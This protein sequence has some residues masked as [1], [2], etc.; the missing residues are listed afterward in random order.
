MP[1]CLVDSTAACVALHQSDHSR[2]YKLLREGMDP[3]PLRGRGV[4]VVLA[5]CMSVV[6]RCGP[7]LPFYSFHE[8]GSGYICGKKVKWGKD[9]RGRQKRWPQAW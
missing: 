2:G 5:R 8:E 6:P 9:E 7:C 4:C 1:L 3:R